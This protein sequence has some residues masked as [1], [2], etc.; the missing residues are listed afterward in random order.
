MAYLPSNASIGPNSLQAPSA[1]EVAA[2][3]AEINAA[4]I[5][6]ARGRL[7][8]FLTVPPI[9]SFSSP[10]VAGDAARILNQSQVARASI[11]GNGSPDT[12]PQGGGGSQSYDDAPEVV[13]L[14]GR[15]SSQVCGGSDSP[16]P[17]AP[18]P[19]MLMPQ[20]APHAVRMRGVQV[21]VQSAPINTSWLQPSGGMTGYA[22]PWGD[23]GLVDVVDGGMV[24]SGSGWL[25]G[26]LA[27]G[28]LV[29]LGSAAAGT[30]ARRKR[31]FK[32]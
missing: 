25:L 21:Y 4:K 14:N 18:P 9:S 12:G 19:Q 31:S 27:V 20:P 5:I 10:T 23:A 3:N 22:P 17:Q 16:Q 30:R 2:S 11:L 24:S 29:M 28:G 32:R 1:C 15:G 7:G 8:T 26:L 13:P 6:A